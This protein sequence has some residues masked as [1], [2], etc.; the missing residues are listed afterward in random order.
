MGVGVLVGVSELVGV[1]VHPPLVQ[2]T[3][4]EGVGVHPPLVQL[5]VGVGVGVHP[6]LVQLTVG[7]GVLVGVHPPLVQLTVREGVT[8]I[9]GV[10]VHPPLVQLTVREGVTE[11]EGVG[12]LVTQPVAVAVGKQHGFSHSSNEADFRYINSALLSENACCTRYKL[13]SPFI[14]VAGRL[15]K[16]SK[17]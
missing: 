5:T 3:V 2:L 12:V 13:H 1:G 7:V 8:D 16:I 10:G 17:L 9:V 4:G 14:S 6:P 11:G 15:V